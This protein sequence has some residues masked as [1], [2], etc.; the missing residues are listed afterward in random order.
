VYVQTCQN[1]YL[2]KHYK[3]RINIMQIALI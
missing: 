1:N 2:S 3:F